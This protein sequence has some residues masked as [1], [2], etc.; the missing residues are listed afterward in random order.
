MK[1]L[2]SRVLP[3]DGKRNDSIRAVAAA[4]AITLLQAMVAKLVC[5]SSNG[6]WYIWCAVSD[7]YTDIHIY[8]V[9]VWTLF[10]QYYGKLEDFLATI[11]RGEY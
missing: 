8:R 2:L 6:F 9:M 4:A 1:Y 3:E 10:V 5:M 11:Q 7:A